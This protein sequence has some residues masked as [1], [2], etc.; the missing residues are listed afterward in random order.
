MVPT[1]YFICFPDTNAPIGGVNQ[2]Y[3]QCA[4]LNALGGRAFVVHQA[5]EFSVSWFDHTTPTLG[6][7]S[8]QAAGL[9][10]EHD[11][12][13][14]PETWTAASTT[15]APGIARAFFN[16]NAY[17]SF[18]VRDFNP[19]FAQ[20]YDQSELFFHLFVSHDNEALIAHCFNLD[21]A[22]TGVFRNGI[23]CGLFA[24]SPERHS[25]ERPQVCYMTR[26]NPDHVAKVIHICEQRGLLERFPFVALQNMPEAEVAEQM[27]RSLLFLS[28][29][30][31]AG[32][33]LP[34]AEAMASGCVVI[35]YHGQGGAEYFLPSHCYPI[36]FGDL[37]AFTRTIET[38][39]VQAQSDRQGLIRMG[40]RARQYI[41]MHHSLAAER[42][43]AALVWNRLFAAWADWKQARG[44][45]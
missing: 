32:S 20:G 42:K 4:L 44:L 23:D 10:P 24:P 3:R 6:M 28:F 31:P 43:Q 13:V 26:K 11:I 30:Y 45:T 38:L 16:Q 14:F 22:A 7:A 18:G 5:E 37:L 34:P 21:P 12:L 17:Y 41:D 15:F 27:A 40:Q 29:E 36:V 25:M 33:P 8:L 39:L 1:V 35:G 19:D 9:K 2:I